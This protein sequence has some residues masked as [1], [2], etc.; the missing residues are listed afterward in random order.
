[1]INK[2]LIDILNKYQNNY[3]EIYK[4]NN[5]ENKNKSGDI[6]LTETN[7]NNTI[8]K[9][10]KNYNIVKYKKY[11]INL[12]ELW[13]GVNSFCII[14]IPINTFIVNDLLIR[15]YNI[16]HNKP[17]VFPYLTTYDQIINIT[18]IQLMNNISIVLES[19][20]D[21]YTKY[22]LFENTN[23]AKENIDQYIKELF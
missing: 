18:Q 21:T 8:N 19:N 23:I 16:K 6:T 7:Y 11:I 14:K 9:F 2:I 3:I 13:Q 10:K 4:I 5:I 20:K 1:M 17:D 15:I 12:H 22:I